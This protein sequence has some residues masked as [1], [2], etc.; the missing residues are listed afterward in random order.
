M[1]SYE[2]TIYIL[3]KNVGVREL[4]GNFQL[5]AY[6]LRAFLVLDISTKKSDMIK[7]IIHV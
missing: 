7:L 2:V 5:S 4:K 1:L 3:R 6:T